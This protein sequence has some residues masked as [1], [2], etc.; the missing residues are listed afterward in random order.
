MI[1]LL[2]L[3]QEGAPTEFND[4]G[5]LLLG[6]VAAAIVVGVALTVVRFK[7]QDKKPPV[8]DF[9]SINSPPNDPGK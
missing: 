1:A 4:L 8:S 2:N 6:G 9:I 7:L 3:L 5:T